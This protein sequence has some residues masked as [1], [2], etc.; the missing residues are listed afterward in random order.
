MYLPRVVK[1]AVDQ[2]S[3]HFDKLY[4][5]VVPDNLGPVE[6]GCRVTVPFG[7]GNVR[8]YEFANP[9][10]SPLAA[11]PICSMPMQRRCA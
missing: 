4:S 10:S 2:A 8:Y 11:R 5:Y 7:G 3:F 9:R 1:V 6:R